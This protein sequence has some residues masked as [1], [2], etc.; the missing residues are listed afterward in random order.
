MSKILT[1]DRFYYDPEF[2]G[3][4]DGRTIRIMSEYYGPLRRLRRKK[5][6]SYTHL[7]LPTKA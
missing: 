4:P 2:V 5:A 3:S 7:T 6:V 1:K